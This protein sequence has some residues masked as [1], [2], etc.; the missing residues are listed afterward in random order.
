MRTSFLERVI[1]SLEDPGREGGKGLVGWIKLEFRAGL[2]ICAPAMSA[3]L[4][5]Q[6]EQQET[7]LQPRSAQYRGGAIRVALS[8]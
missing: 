7:N 8:E 5:Q 2:D 6:A 3:V 1:H 4:Y